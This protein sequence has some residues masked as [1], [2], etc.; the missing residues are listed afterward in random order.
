EVASSSGTRSKAPPE[1][2]PDPPRRLAAR[3]PRRRERRLGRALESA[4][5]HLSP[6]AAAGKEM[7]RAAAT[8]ER[9]HLPV[10]EVV[11]NP[12]E[13]DQRDVAGPVVPTDDVLLEQDRGD[14]EE[15]GK[16]DRD[17]EKGEQELDGE[18]TEQPCGQDD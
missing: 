9:C 15:H 18:R 3:R 14:R 5:L 12:V 1:P 8:P 10:A 7:E 13:D 11:E 6:V 16:Q 2:P 17:R 4:P